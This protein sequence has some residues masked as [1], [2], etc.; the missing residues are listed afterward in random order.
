VKQKTKY[1]QTIVRIMLVRVVLQ[2]VN[3]HFKPNLRVVGSSKGFRPFRYKVANQ[4]QNCR[5]NGADPDGLSGNVV[6][7]CN[8]AVAR[9]G[10]VRARDAG[11]TTRTCWRRID[12]GNL[13]PLLLGTA[14]DLVQERSSGCHPN[15]T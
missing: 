1:A 4:T 9:V 3:L 15:G 10:S 5:H 7:G 6:A 8:D 2:K 12:A 11:V 14:R 13:G